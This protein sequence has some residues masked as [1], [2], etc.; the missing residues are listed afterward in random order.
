MSN[1]SYAFHP[2]ETLASE[3]LAQLALDLRWSWNHSADELWRQIDPELWSLTH[4]PW[5]LLQTA[6]QEKLNELAKDSA[7]QQ[8][9]EALLKLRTEALESPGWFQQAHAGS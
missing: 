2:S 3:A 6:S 1:P 7:F 5:L 9:L 4:N 8:R